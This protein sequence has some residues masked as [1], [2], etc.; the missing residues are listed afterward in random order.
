MTIVCRGRGFKVHRNVLC[1]ASKFFA[2]ACDG[3]FK[4]ARNATID[5]SEDDPDT[6]QRML[7]YLYT[8]DYDDED[9]GQIVPT[10]VI[11]AR[12][13]NE[14]RTG[15]GTQ[16]LEK[17]SIHHKPAQTS[18]KSTVATVDPIEDEIDE[19][20]SDA[21]EKRTSAPLKNV[22]VYALAEKYDLQP[23]K[24]L[25][26][27]KFEIRSAESWQV[28]DIV[29]VLKA[30]YGTTPSTDRGLRDIIINE[31]RQMLYDDSALAVEMLDQL[32]NT[33]RQEVFDLERDKV[34]LK[35]EIRDQQSKLKIEK[36]IQLST[37]QGELDLTREEKRLLVQSLQTFS[38]RQCKKGLVLDVVRAAG[39][40]F[41][42]NHKNIQLLLGMLTIGPWALLIVYDIL[43]W[44]FRSI[45]YIIPFVGGRARGKKRPRAPSL[46]ERASGRRRTFSIGGT[47]LAGTDHSEKDG[48]R[49]RIL[50]IG[51]QDDPADTDRGD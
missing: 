15:P 25:A 16:G 28:N 36:Q 33:A 27:C 4:E 42:A 19:S 10:K 49:K 40:G 37:L 34:K 30:V 13:G 1:P 7:V 12:A 11:N 6:I 22:L 17:N 50:D 14:S 51:M 20:P 35:D 45:L 29:D 46:S 48:L 38:C 3:G 26:R 21:G 43:L 41:Y 24:E 9:S 2:A 23:L 31:L 39:V 8:A 5:L 44:V 32:H 18:A 47:Q